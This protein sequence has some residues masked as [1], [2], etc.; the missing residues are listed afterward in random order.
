MPLRPSEISFQYADKS[1]APG[2]RHPSPTTA[3]GISWGNKEVI[4]GLL[5]CAG[6][7]AQRQEVESRSVKSFQTLSDGI[8]GYLVG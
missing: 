8:L 3:M 2:S 4:M 1:S 5:L 6:L 7:S